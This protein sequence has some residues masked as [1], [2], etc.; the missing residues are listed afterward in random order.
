VKER[1]ILFSAPMVLAILAGRKTQTRRALRDQQPADLGAAM[2]GGHLS[3]RSVHHHGKLVGHRMA[4]VACPYGVPG[5]RLWVKETFARESTGTLYR[6]S[7]AEDDSDE[8]CG[9]W[10]GE[11]FFPGPITWTPSIFMPRAFSRI[12]L[13]VTG[14]RVERLHDISEADAQAEGILR[15]ERGWCSDEGQ[16]VSITARRAYEDLWH[17]INAKRGGWGA[18]PWVWVVGFR[19]VA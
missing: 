6:A 4:P 1:P 15:T 3:R 12:A 10:Q 5:D 7:A 8:R 19:R 9:W 11:R 16:P 13:E 14:V 2:H 17:A 18:N